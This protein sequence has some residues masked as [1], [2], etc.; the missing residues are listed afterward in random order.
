M[1]RLPIL[2]QIHLSRPRPR[3]RHPLPSS[4]KE[5]VEETTARVVAKLLVGVTVVNLPIHSQC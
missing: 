5:V 4:V 3:P 2:Y 1:D